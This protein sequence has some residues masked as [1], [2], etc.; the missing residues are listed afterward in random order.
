MKCEVRKSNPAY[1]PATSGKSAYAKTS[2]RKTWAQR[3]QRE[4]SILSPD[5]LID[6]KHQHG[7][8]L[9]NVELEMS[10]EIHTQ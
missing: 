4:I 3:K 2:T 10:E 7:F 6:R 8:I 9:V 1:V 5:C